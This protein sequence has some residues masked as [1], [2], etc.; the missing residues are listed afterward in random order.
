MEPDSMADCP[1]CRIVAGE[2]PAF[3]IHEDDRT[4]AMMDINPV[5]DGHALVIAK[6]HAPDLYSIAAGDLSAVAAACQRVASAVHRAVEPSG[7]NV[8]QA[9][10][11][12]AGQSVQHFHMHIVPRSE[13]DGLTMTWVHTPGD[14]E[15]IAEIAAR[16]RRLL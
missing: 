12:G 6:A 1:F 8:L 15:R 14:G 9:N 5:A 13:G 10:G 16:I 3:K 11:P 7:I 2:I 4:L